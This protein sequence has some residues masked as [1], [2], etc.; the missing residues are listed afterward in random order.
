MSFVE[1]CHSALSV[2]AIVYRI[3]LIESVASF[4]LVVPLTDVWLFTA[5]NPYV[6][7]GGRKAKKVKRNIDILYQESKFILPSFAAIRDGKG[8]Q[9]KRQQRS[10]MESVFIV[11]SSEENDES[12]WYEKIFLFLIF[13]IFRLLIVYTY[14]MICSRTVK[15]W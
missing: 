7:S 15:K 1:C 8:G 3:E 4:W 5:T 9:Q 14:W 11:Q 6:G 2:N 13:I 12:K 10:R